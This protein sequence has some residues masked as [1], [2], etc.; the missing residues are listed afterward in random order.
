MK[1][2]KIHNCLNSETVKSGIY[3]KE[4][5]KQIQILRISLPFIS[6]CLLSIH[7][8]LFRFIFVLF[9]REVYHEIFFGS[10]F[11]CYIV[12]CCDCV[13]IP[14]TFFSSSSFHFQYCYDFC[15]RC[16]NENNVIYNLYV[17]V[18]SPLY[19][20]RLLLEW[21]KHKHHTRN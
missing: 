7:F 11:F 18:N 14:W 16:F 2:K 21:S 15:L 12:I 9:M 10:K 6:C 1:R 20:T 5:K 17:N 4:E 3:L 19:I 8:F 13:E